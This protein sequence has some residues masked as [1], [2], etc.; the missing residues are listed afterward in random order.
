MFA[1][2]AIAIIALIVAV[3]ACIMMAKRTTSSDEGGANNDNPDVEEGRR[4]CVVRGT[5]WV[6]STQI[7]V[8]HDPYDEK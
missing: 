7:T 6:T 4:I 1:S 3:C 8:Y 5:T 2:L